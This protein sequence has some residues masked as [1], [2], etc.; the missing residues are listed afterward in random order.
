MSQVI[1]FLDF[2]GVITYTYRGGVTSPQ[3]AFDYDAIKLLKSAIDTNNAKLVISSTWRDDVS[4]STFNTLLDAVGLSNCLY[5]GKDRDND[6]RT[7]LSH[8]SVRGNQIKRWLDAHPE[9]TDY[10]IVDDDHDML[11][12]QMNKFVHVDAREGFSYIDMVAVNA[13]FTKHD[14]AFELYPFKPKGIKHERLF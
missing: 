6:W 10:C 14:N 12:E 2:D 4:Y 8:D 3:S 5:V 9:V 13:C 7:E 11:P 1:I